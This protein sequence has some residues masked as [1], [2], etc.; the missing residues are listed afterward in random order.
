MFSFIMVGKISTFL[1]QHICDF[2]FKD[3]VI[4][5]IFCKFDI[6]MQFAMKSVL[7]FFNPF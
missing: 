4:N 5:W 1:T 2:F 3:P 7:F 6:D